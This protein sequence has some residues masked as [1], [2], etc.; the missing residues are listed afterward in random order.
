MIY[1]AHALVYSR[2]PAETRAVLDIVLGTRNVDAG[3]GWLIFALPPSEI[4]V[5]P[6]DGASRIDLYLM[7]QDIE[8]TILQLREKGVK[9]SKP[10]H[11]ESWGRVTAIAL[12]DGGELGLYQ[13]RHA[14]P[15]ARPSAGPKSSAKKPRG[16][17]NGGRSRAAR[18]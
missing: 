6:T 9:F 4:A 11:D 16:A 7:C 1:G 10:I 17:S 8:K 3:G 12:P 2:A 14:S 13:P 18:V 5:H 15:I